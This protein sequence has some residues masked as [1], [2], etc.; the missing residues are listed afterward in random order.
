MRPRSDKTLSMM[1]A[2]FGS[3]RYIA[4]E[5]EIVPE[6]YKSSQGGIEEPKSIFNDSINASSSGLPETPFEDDISV[7]SP[8]ATS[9]PLPTFAD[10]QVDFK[11]NDYTYTLRVLIQYLTSLHKNKQEKKST[12]EEFTI[13]L[14]L[15]PSIA[16]ISASSVIESRRAITIVVDP[17]SPETIEPK[18]PPEFPR[19]TILDPQNGNYLQTKA[20]NLR[21]M[22]NAESLKRIQVSTVYELYNL[23][24]DVFLNAVSLYSQG[25]GG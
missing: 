14:T 5:A 16:G 15:S 2:E 24:L 17:L 11:K 12:P 20:A 6:A 25:Y 9:N 10:S 23:Y 19:Q 13:D 21:I 8:I 4:N 18:Q 1:A 22:K 3:N 7:E